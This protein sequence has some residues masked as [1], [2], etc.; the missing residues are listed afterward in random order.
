MFNKKN[1]VNIFMFAIAM[2]QNI[3]YSILFI[4][5]TLK[6]ISCFRKKKKLLPAILYKPSLLK[7][8]LFTRDLAFR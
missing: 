1:S 3:V 7:N 8:V 6:I 4:S 5:C 2:M